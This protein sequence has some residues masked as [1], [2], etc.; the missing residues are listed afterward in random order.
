VVESRRTGA[1]RFGK[2]DRGRTV[3]RLNAQI[4]GDA[5]GPAGDYKDTLTVTLRAR[6]GS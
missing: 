3:H 6:V 5:D 2:G 1:L 4:T